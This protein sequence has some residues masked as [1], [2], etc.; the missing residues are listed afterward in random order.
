MASTDPGK[1]TGGGARWP[2]LVPSWPTGWCEQSTEQ[3]RV[4]IGMAWYLLTLQDSG[5]YNNMEPTPRNMWQLEIEILLQC[6]LLIKTLIRTRL[7]TTQQQRLD[8]DIKNSLYG[9]VVCLRVLRKV[10]LSIRVLSKVRI[11]PD[12]TDWGWCMTAPTH[13]SFALISPCYRLLQNM[14]KKMGAV[15]DVC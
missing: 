13:A 1:L 2:D 9:P 3:I 12:L 15:A 7:D 10:L 6:L 4:E 8:N 11:F 14:N 5:K